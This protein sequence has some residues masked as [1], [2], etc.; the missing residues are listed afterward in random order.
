MI[1]TIL[2]AFTAALLLNACIS[3]PPGV[4]GGPTPPIPGVASKEDEDKAFRQGYGFG[5]RDAELGKQ[6]NFMLYNNYYD[7]STKNTFSRGYMSGYRHG[8]R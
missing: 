4:P 6:S 3:S 8:Q 7:S 2:P 1:R 5:K